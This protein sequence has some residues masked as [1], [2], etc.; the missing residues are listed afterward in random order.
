MAAQ[1][2]SFDDIVILV[3]FERRQLDPNQLTAI[4]SGCHCTC[5]GRVPGVLTRTVLLDMDQANFLPR[6]PE[7]V[8]LKRYG[9]N[10]LHDRTE[11][12]VLV[13]LLQRFRNLRVLILLAA[14]L[15]RPRPALAA[16][17]L[18]IVLA[19]LILPFTEFGHYYGLLAPP[20][21]L[22]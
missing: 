13:E 14:I 19:A 17:S 22:S 10:Q 20:V 8:R 3:R 4:Q 2:G 18:A 5:H 1:P 21:G 11:R 16:T 6:I 9:R 12:S 15:I 7:R